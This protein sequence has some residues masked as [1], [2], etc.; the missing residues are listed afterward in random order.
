M[1]VFLCPQVT[2]SCTFL[3]ST[4][5][6]STFSRILFS[7]SIVFSLHPC[8]GWTTVGPFLMFCHSPFG[9]LTFCLLPSMHF[10]PHVP[11]REHLCCHTRN[12][13]LVA[14]SQ[15]GSPAIWGRCTPHP[16]VMV[17]LIKTW[18]FSVKQGNPGPST[19]SPLSLHLV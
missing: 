9:L 17:G 3:R 14:S 19:P 4:V 10:S 6:S 1:S 8:G 12:F 18:F 2:F 16:T 7:F 5:R 13:F 11:L 15:C